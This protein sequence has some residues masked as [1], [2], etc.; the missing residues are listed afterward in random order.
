MKHVDPDKVVYTRPYIPRWVKITY[1][2]I[3]APIV[4]IVIPFLLLM[5]FAFA[6]ALR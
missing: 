2:I 1:A 6:G 4:L 5:A 3:L